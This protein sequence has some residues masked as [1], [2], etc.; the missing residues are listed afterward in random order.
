MIDSKKALSRNLRQLLSAHNMIVKDLSDNLQLPYNTVLGWCNGT[1]YPRSDKLDKLA[2]YFNVPRSAIVDNPATTSVTVIS[3]N[4]AP[5]INSN[6]I[7]GN[8][9]INSQLTDA[10][11]EVCQMYQ[12]LPPEAKQQINNLVKI[13]YNMNGNTKDNKQGEM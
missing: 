2:E 5:I 3:D 9:T 7:D 4:T 6:N 11:G 8:I 12:S 13:M 10:L 1:S